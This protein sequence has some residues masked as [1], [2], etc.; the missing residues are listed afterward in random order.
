MKFRIEKDTKVIAHHEGASWHIKTGFVPLT[1][2]VRVTFDM[3]DLW[4]APLDL[5]LNGSGTEVLL[6]GNITD[7]DWYKHVIR[8][9]Y[10]FNLPKN[11]RDVECIIVERADV[12]L[13]HPEGE[14]RQSEEHSHV[15]EE[16][17]LLRRMNQQSGI[18][19]GKLS[20]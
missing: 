1:T 8:N 4:F 18:Y 6:A 20:K 14:A 17:K 9:F 5:N 2:D 19:P 11:A 13:I 7:Q 12:Q 10:G 3:G 15:R 16:K